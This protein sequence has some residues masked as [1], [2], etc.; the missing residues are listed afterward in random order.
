MSID[1]RLLARQAATRAASTTPGSQEWAKRYYGDPGPPGSA[2]GQRW[3]AK[4]IIVADIFGR[5]LR[6]HRD[7][8]RAFLLLDHIFY[9]HNKRYWKNIN[10]GTYDDWG[11]NHRY[12][13]G[14]FILSNHAFGLAT[15]LNATKNSRTSD[16]NE[17]NSQI[18]R[19][20]RSSI[21][22]A[23]RSG[24]FRWGGRY[25]SPD[26]MHFEVIWTPVQQRDHLDRFGRWRK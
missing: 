5:E 1:E 15:D 7:A 9:R 11:W 20:A 4:N 12:I 26:P 24:C 8:K 25:G 19:K 14:T 22:A 10:E 21:L 3:A 2:Q 6:I 13:A 18:W 16:P 17:K 23:E